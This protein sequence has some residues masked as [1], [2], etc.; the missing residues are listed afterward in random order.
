MTNMTPTNLNQ[1]QNPWHIESKGA[2]ENMDACK[3]EHEH[4]NFEGFPD[5]F[6]EVILWT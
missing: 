5:H 3:H 6:Q 1:S 2:P 4:L